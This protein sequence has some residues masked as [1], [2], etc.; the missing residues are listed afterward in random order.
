MIKRDFL[1]DKNLRGPIEITVIVIVAVVVAIV[2]RAFLLQLFYI[3][4]PSMDPTLKVN[5]KI[6]VN[7][8]SYNFHD[9]ERGDIVVFDAPK[10]I[11]ENSVAQ[12]NINK[13]AP[14][15]KDLIKRVIG[16]P[17]ETVEG[18]C[19]DDSLMCELDIYIDG[20]K[21][22]EPYLVPG[23]L[24][25]PFSSGQIPA[26]SYFVMGDNRDNSEDGRI[27]GPIDKDMI[28]GRAFFRIWPG[29][30]FGFL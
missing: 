1:K 12:H 9:I 19:K 3:P 18:K 17:G 30:K 29:S 6:F 4:S 5:D 13:D 14:V 16:L 27:F 8:L 11:Y 10:S 2:V 22:N 20:K 23:M 28:V 24:N 7:K 21:L 26:N 15:I 25:A